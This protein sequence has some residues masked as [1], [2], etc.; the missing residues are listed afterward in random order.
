MTVVASAWPAGMDRRR[1]SG[2]LPA[3]C[4]WDRRV[5]LLDSEAAALLTLG[6]ARLRRNGAVGIPR[7]TALHWRALTRLTEPL[8]AAVAGLHHGDDVRFRRA[9]RQAAAI[10]LQHC[11][12]TGRSCWGWTPWEW[13]RLCGG[14]AREFLAAQSLPTEPTVRPFVVALA[15]LLGGFT[16][17]HRLGTFNRLHLACLIFGEPAVDEAMCC[18]EEVLDRWGYHISKGTR[19]RMRGV[20]SQAL[21]LNRSPRL[22]DLDTAAFAALRAHPATDGHQ[23]SMLYALQRVVAA[24]GHCDPPV[25]TGYLQPAGIEGADPVWAA[26]IERWHATPTLT[27]KVRRLIRTI[28]GKAGRWLAVEHP[29]ITDPGQ[30]TRATCAA[31]V[32]AVDR[33]SVGDWTQRRDALGG[34]GGQPV[35]PRTKAHNL[36][37]TRVFFRDC[38]EWEWIPRRFDPN[39]ALAL[40][41]SIAALIGTNPRVIA[42][43]VWAKLLWAGLNLAPTDLPGNSADTYYPME[44]I[45]AVTLTWLFSGLRS[46]E[47][48]R[49]RVGCIRW[50]HDGLPIPGDSH[51]ILAEDAVCLL[52]V[53]VNKTGIA[54]TKP[55]DPIVGQAIEAWQALRPSQP[56][57]L[58]R[59]T[60]EHVD[61]LFSVRAQPVAKYY[62]NHTIIPALCGKAGVPTSDIR[63]NITSHRARSTIASQ[64][65]NAKEPMTL[66]ELQ[67]WLGHRTP[68]STQHYAK[69]TPHT[70]SKAY[71]EAGYFARNVRTIEV[72]VDRGAVTSGA[73]AAGQPWQHYDLGHGWCTYSFFEQCPHRMACARCDFYTPKDSTKGQL[74]EASDN[75]QRMLASIPLSDEERAAVDDGHTAVTAL[76]DRLADVPTPAGPTP[77]ELGTPATVTMLPI[78]QIQTG[79]SS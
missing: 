55:V 1:L 2:H 34:R 24:L 16:D 18:A 62:I 60:S 21:L 30:W 28:M 53:P 51:D 5:A 35:S 46:D 63:G 71:A 65:Y 29:E 78:V 19:S 45:R 72:L 73:A 54:F 11:A 26:W 25:R 4:R 33:M 67:A 70:L 75:L 52:D 9:G 32:A 7:R 48:S 6:P 15:Y 31:W 41:R 23:G 74:L 42:D 27:P 43:E 22:E 17:F 47:I 37:A 38:Q 20:F 58:D 36:M 69:I 3:D 68:H 12:D 49:L 10:V 79:K 14:S 50:Q 57:R 39:R 59:K 77:R 64:L 76:L 56:K 8:D 61:M 44:L 66:F 40:P 13:A